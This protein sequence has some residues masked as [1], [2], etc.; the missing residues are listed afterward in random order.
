MTMNEFIDYC[1]YHRKQLIVMLVVMVLIIG[2]FISAMKYS[3]E[4]NKL[5]IENVVGD[6]KY[7]RGEKETKLE[8]GSS[9]YCG[10]TFY[11]GKDSSATVIFD[12]DK[13]VELLSNCTMEVSS[14][15]SI[16][17]VN[18][19]GT[20][21][22]VKSYTVTIINGAAIVDV[23]S[24]GDNGLFQVLTKEV[25]YLA[26]AS[27][28]EICRREEYGT[29]YITVD[30]GNLEITTGGNRKLKAG[31]SV[32]CKDGKVKNCAIMT[33]KKKDAFLFSY[34]VGEMEEY[35][36]IYSGDRVG[37]SN[38]LYVHAD[39]RVDIRDLEQ[40][41]KVYDILE[42][43]YTKANAGETSINVTLANGNRIK[44]H[45][46]DN[47]NGILTFDPIDSDSIYNKVL[48]EFL[49]RDSR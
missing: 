9:V 37:E 21:S 34:K 27:K 39:T 1:K 23:K 22:T 33:L 13:T 3:S 44:V 36:E 18:Y 8:D 26:G 5:T 25:K 10:G 15:N 7:I 16:A 32:Y 6:V 24:A 29:T 31:Q 19:L 28:T 12:E 47:N 40:A 4:G 35:Y 41:Q 17:D 46:I 43:I 11:V 42:E 49:V 20:Y 30:R 14:K 2:Y 48:I 38:I 45:I